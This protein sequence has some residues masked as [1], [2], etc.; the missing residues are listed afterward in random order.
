M[1]SCHHAIVR[2]GP[3]VAGLCALPLDRSGVA[4]CI[5]S[6]R[7]CRRSSLSRLVLCWGW[8]TQKAMSMRASDR[9]KATAPIRRRKLYEEVVIR[10][11]TWIHEG[12][13]KP[14]DPLPSERE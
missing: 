10:L 7:R 14:G 5:V 3:I 6:A 13:L 2:C 12:E 8:I 9:M 4:G 11:E 1:V